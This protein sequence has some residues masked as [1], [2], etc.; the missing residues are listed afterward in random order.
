[1][2]VQADGS[3][4]ITYRI[5]N[6]PPGTVPTSTTST[7]PNDIIYLGGD[8]WSI[9]EDAIAGLTL[10]PRFNYAGTDPYPG[11]EIFAVTQEIDGDQDIS[12]AWLV[13]FAIEPVIDGIELPFTL[14]TSISESIN[15]VNQTGISLKTATGFKLL[16][17]KTV[18][19]GLRSLCP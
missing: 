15:E 7:T 18:R 17:G 16:D 5:T 3:E 14:S 1:M 9:A 10:P 19:V 11:L 4:N 13:D 8:A 6:I 12:A 2:L